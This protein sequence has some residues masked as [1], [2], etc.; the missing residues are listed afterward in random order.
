[1]ALDVLAALRPQ[2]WIAPV[3]LFEAGRATAGAAHPPFP[4][5]SA[6]A[7]A[8]LVS[9]LAIL[10]AVHVANGW[11]DRH[12]DRL[13]RK[14][15]AIAAGRIGAV[16]A[17]VIALACIV[18]A[19]AAAA[20][21]GVSNDTRLLL[22]ACGVLGA[23]YVTPPVEL[24]RRPWLDLAAQAAGY[25]I[26]A[27]AIGHVAVGPLSARGLLA[28]SPYATGIAVVGLIAMIAD[29][30]GDEAAGQRTTAVALGPGGS[31]QLAIGLAGL[32]AAVGWGIGDAVPAFWGILAMAWLALHA[33]AQGAGDGDDVGEGDDPAPWIRAAISLQL[34]FA[35]LLLHRTAWPLLSAIV[36]GAATA[37][38][39]GRVSGTNYPWSAWR[40][41]SSAGASG[42]T[43]SAEAD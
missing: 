34:L 6:A 37:A 8:S 35:L 21:P 32:T 13:N 10:G 22:G 40:R 25:G 33:P 18:V 39:S 11:R 23:A 7:L 27:F 4:P 29:R 43:G 16:P 38:L 14:G 3:A 19:A 42:R 1:M 2:L 12:T 26:L 41:T 36:L 9:L 5:F 24:K 17:A 20:H 31:T 30:R 28:A 15:G